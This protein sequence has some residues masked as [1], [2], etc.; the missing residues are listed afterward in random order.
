MTDS[1][2]P[3]E[4]QALA[5][6]V[7]LACLDAAL[8]AWEAAGQQG[9]CAEGRWE[10]AVGAIQSVDLAALLAAPSGPPA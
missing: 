5:R 6:R 10:A 8:Q 9:L 7:Q 1:H 3:R 4:P 2:D